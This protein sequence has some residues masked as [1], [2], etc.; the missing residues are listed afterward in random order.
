MS[1][2]PLAYLPNRGTL[3]RFIN[4]GDYKGIDVFPR[5][6]RKL[7]KTIRIVLSLFWKGAC[8]KFFVMLSKLI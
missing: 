8:L 4:G 3:S 2:T 5:G 1:K 6:A 7:M